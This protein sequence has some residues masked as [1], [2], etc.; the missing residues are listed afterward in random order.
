MIKAVIFDMDGVLV[1][2]EPLHYLAWKS[3]FEN[4]GSSLSEKEFTSFV[5]KGNPAVASHLISTLNLK[6]KEEKIIEEKNRIYSELIKNVKTRKGAKEILLKLKNRTKLCLASSSKREDV[7][8]ILKIVNL[9]QLFDVI[10]TGDEVERIKPYPDIYF[11]AAKKLNLKPRE[12]VVFEDSS[13]GVLSAKTAGMFC[14]AVP[15]KFSKKQD[16]SKADMIR[17]SL[18]EVDIEEALKMDEI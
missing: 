8:P 2:T 12:C 11:L 17:D 7:F 15:H 13:V 6:V 14:I 5:G 3:V 16:F 9:M 18:K 10:V 4:H 1:D